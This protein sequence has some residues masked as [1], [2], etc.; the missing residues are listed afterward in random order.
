MPARLSVAGHIIIA[1]E[2]QRPPPGAASLGSCTHA[3]RTGAWGLW[4]LEGA[5]R[6]LNLRG[7]ALG[8]C[9]K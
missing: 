5:R 9:I 6:L 4:E 1:A 7:I 8:N 3:Y 2:K